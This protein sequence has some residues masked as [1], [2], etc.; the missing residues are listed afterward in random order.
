MVERAIN[1]ECLTQHCWSPGQS[2][3]IADSAAPLHCAD[4]PYRF[5]GSDQHSASGS[6]RLCDSI[7]AVLGVDRVDVQCS[8]WAEH[9][10]IPR[11]FSTGAVTGR[12]AVGQI[13]FG[14]NNLTTNPLVP[15][16]S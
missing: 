10:G 1:I 13:G 3:Q 14:L 4:P 15:I 11:G 9:G 8:R 12:V 2:A 6:R 16:F 7:Q 5:D